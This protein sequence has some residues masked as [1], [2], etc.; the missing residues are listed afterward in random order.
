MFKIFSF[1]LGDIFNLN[2][3]EKIG[4]FV[5][6]VLDNIDKNELIRAM[7]Q[8]RVNGRDKSAFVAIDMFI[9]VAVSGYRSLLRKLAL[10]ALFLFLFNLLL[11]QHQQ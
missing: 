5:Q 4:G 2:N 6:S 10:K 9:Q 11:D 8:A 7:S 3:L 1:G